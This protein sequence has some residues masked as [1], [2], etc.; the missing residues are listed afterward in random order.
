MSESK[1]D[2]VDIL[3]IG[4]G[5]DIALGRPTKYTDFIEFL[6][7]PGYADEIKKIQETGIVSKGFKKYV[8]SRPEDRTRIDINELKRMRSL[9][10]NNSWIKYFLGCNADIKG[11]IDLER[12]MI[13]VISLFQWA[14]SQKYYMVT[15]GQFGTT[16][17]STYGRVI[18]PEGS[19]IPTNV[20]KFWERYL[21]IESRTNTFLEINAKYCDYQYGVFTEKI[22]DDL[23]NE[24][25]EFI[26][27]FR[28]YLREIVDQ[29]DVAE[30]MRIKS[31]NA[32][33]LISF[34]YTQTELL[35]KN[36]SSIAKETYHIHG[37]VSKKN[38]MVLGVNE[39][40]NDETNEFIFATK[41][42]QRL[43]K[44]S[45]PNYRKYLDKSFNLIV[46]GHSLDTTDIAILRP[47]IEKAQKV[48]VYYYSG[49]DYDQKLINLIKLVTLEILE[50]R[51]FDNSIVFEET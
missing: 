26:E 34:N 30:N 14:L 20:A 44:R 37:V 35:L 1:K 38:S 49:M 21:H 16:E 29:K 4:N 18:V 23:K 13:P 32:D 27:I 28:I 42:Y 6:R 2:T 25:D 36:L 51:M 22:I 5:F 9:A 10:D 3:L 50:E 45:N 12:E 46:Y 8:S 43:R 47:F 7:L 19:H 15:E 11:W 48:T 24:L 31:L 17:A 40:K 41:P 33:V 39:V